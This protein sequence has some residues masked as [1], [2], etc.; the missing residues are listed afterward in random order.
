VVLAQV[1][2]WRDLLGVALVIGGVALHRTGDGADR[3]GRSAD[4]DVVAAP[5]G[6][7]D[8]QA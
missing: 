1:P 5:D 7:G 2:T 8:A 3:A 4:D 6:A